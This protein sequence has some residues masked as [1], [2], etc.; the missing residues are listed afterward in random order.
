MA[1][2][3]LL[4]GGFDVLHRGHI[5]LLKRSSDLGDQLYIGLTSDDTIK[6]R[7]GKDRPVLGYGDR[8]DILMATKYVYSVSPISGLNNGEITRS[9]RELIGKIK[10]DIITAGWHG[11]ADE[12]MIPICRGDECLSYVKIYHRYSDIHTTDIIEK[13]RGV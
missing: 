9:T 11:T 4:T 7:K 13:I 8:R 10:P 2:K 3:I 5:E 12:F 1:K 6:N